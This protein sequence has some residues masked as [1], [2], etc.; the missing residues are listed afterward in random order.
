M[1]TGGQL[2]HADIDTIDGRPGND[3]ITGKQQNDTLTGGGGQDR[4]I[5]NL[6]DGR[7]TIID[8]GGVGQGNN[9]TVAT[10]AEIDII[11]FQGTGLTSRNMILTTVGADLEI[12]FEGNPS[13]A[14]ILQNFQLE[15][16]ENTWLPLRNV[17]KKLVIGM[18]LT[19]RHFDA[20]TEDLVATLVELEVPQALIDEV[21]QISG[22]VA[23]RNEALK[24]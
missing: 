17:H 5:Y 3:Q 14:I 16:L 7:D 13:T 18:S 24:Y 19:D 1:V 2:S 12:T 11:Q 4:F 10:R 6:G 23:H 9:P 22:F 8:F 15:N 21:A 20:I